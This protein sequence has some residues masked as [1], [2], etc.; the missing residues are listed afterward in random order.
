MS[1]E[2][3][4]TRN[5]PAHNV[6]RVLA[7]H[8]LDATAARPSAAN[9]SDTHTTKIAMSSHDGLRRPA[10][11]VNPADPRRPQSTSPKSPGTRMTLYRKE[12][13]VNIENHRNFSGN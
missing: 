6:D 13:R 10:H 12:L 7:G 5:A 9:G 11:I 1:S 8:R 3:T 2:H 4:V